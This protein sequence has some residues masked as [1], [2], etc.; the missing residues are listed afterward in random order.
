MPPRDRK[1]KTSGRERADGTSR[2]REAGFGP[3]ATEHPAPP[4]EGK[5]SGV[6]T[7]VRGLLARR[8]GA[9]RQD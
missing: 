5:W 9:R 4:A 7:R 3:G 2:V 8:R 1:A 6:L